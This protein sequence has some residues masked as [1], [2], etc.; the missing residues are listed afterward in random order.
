MSAAALQDAFAYLASDLFPWVAFLHH[1]LFGCALG[2]VLSGNRKPAFT[3]LTLSF[4]SMC[5]SVVAAAGDDHI[6]QTWISALFMVLMFCLLFEVWR[7][8][9]VWSKGARRPVWVRRIAF[10]GIAWAWVY[11]AYL[12]SWWLA[13][14]MAPLGVL[15]SPTL[16]ALLSCLL[17]AFPNTS[18]LVHWAAAFLGILFASLGVFYLWNW[19][20]IPLLLIAS[21]TMRELIQSA[22]AAG[23]V[24]AD[25]DP[26]GSSPGPPAP[27]VRKERIY[28]L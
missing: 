18:R 2:A 19:S 15:P 13:P 21:I 12:R 25:D 14:V 7:G 27:Q 17:L 1:V 26:P 9:T 5:F 10:A 24:F 3:L 4:A 22:R 8:E 6:E 16:L 20:D 23:G 11:P 28:K